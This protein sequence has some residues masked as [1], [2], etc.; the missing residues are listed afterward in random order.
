MPKIKRH[1]ARFTT[2]VQKW[3]RHNA[4]DLPLA[5]AW[6]AKVATTPNLFFSQVPKHQRDALEIAKWQVFC[7]K[8]SDYDQMKKPCDG[9][10]M[11]DAGGMLLLHWIRKGNKTFY[12]IDIDRFQAFEKSCGKKSLNEDDARK[13]AFKVGTL[14]N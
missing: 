3:L 1:E 9:V 6:E 4:K 14:K 5:F 2:E 7:Y 12:M 10:F 11:R 13:I 8:I